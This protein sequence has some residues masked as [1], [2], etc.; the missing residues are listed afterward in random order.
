MR[1]TIEQ[2]AGQLTKIE[3]ITDDESN[4]SAIMPEKPDEEIRSD[5]SKDK[6]TDKKPSK[7]IKLMG[8]EMKPMNDKFGLPKASGV[9]SPDEVILAENHDFKYITLCRS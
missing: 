7:E 9:F 5:D 2:R 4:V 3:I 1:I 6:K 8:S